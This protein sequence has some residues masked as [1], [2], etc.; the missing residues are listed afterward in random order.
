VGSRLPTRIGIAAAAGIIA[1]IVLGTALWFLGDGLRLLLEARGFALAAAA[2]LAGGAG[3]LVAVA[4]G[5]L[6]VWTLR[7]HPRRAKAADASAAATELGALVAREIVN[8]SRE[9]PYGTMGAALVAGLAV[10]A[11]PELRK[12]LA[13]LLKR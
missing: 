11:L 1:L 13:D 4:L 9:H 12:L 10:G 6:G 2:G 5:L 3:L 8:A 7:R